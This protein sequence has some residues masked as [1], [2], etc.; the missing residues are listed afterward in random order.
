MMCYRDQNL[1][2]IQVHT[3]KMLHN[4]SPVYGLTVRQW[5]HM[6]NWAL[7][8][9]KLA[10]IPILSLCTCGYKSH[11]ISRGFCETLSSREEGERGVRSDTD[12]GT[13]PNLQTA[14]D[15]HTYNGLQATTV[16]SVCF[17]NTNSSPWL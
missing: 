11:L 12:C 3:M 14:I 5:L 7:C 6:V 16:K 10:V 13:I 4:P 9:K 17:Y 15:T 1:Y 2:F 8:W